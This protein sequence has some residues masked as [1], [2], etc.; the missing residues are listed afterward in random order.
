MLTQLYTHSLIEPSE[1]LKESAS[2][3]DYLNATWRFVLPSDNDH[4]NFINTLVKKQ[5]GLTP[6]DVE[7]LSEFIIEG[8]V[9]AMMEPIN[10]NTGYWRV[11]GNTKDIKLNS[12]LK[13]LIQIFP[14]N[15]VEALSN[16]AAKDLAAK[17][18]RT[19]NYLQRNSNMYL[20]GIIK[21]SE[22][23]QSDKSFKFYDRSNFFTYEPT[24]FEKQLSMLL[25]ITTPLGEVEFAE[26][27]R[28]LV[29][30]VV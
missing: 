14:I 29:Q 16:I 21:Y 4:T 20:A 15:H 8:R 26:F 24:A 27:Q 1:P 12:A 5:V 10:S 22:L 28:K 3:A 11:F 13:N 17:Y 9:R 2:E 30:Y 7:Q 19:Y 6:C 23:A 25:H 18:H